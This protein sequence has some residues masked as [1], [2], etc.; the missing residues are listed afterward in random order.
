M[1]ALRSRDVIASGRS[2]P[3]LTNAIALEMSTNIMEMRPP[4]RSVSAGGLLR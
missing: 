3:A 1:I 2:W 4:I